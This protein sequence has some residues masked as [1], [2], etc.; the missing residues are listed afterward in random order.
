VYLIDLEQERHLDVMLAVGDTARV[1][2]VTP[3][4]AHFYADQP[5]SSTVVIG[6]LDHEVR[7]AV[8]NALAPH[9][10]NYHPGYRQYGSLYGL[11]RRDAPRGTSRGQCDP[12]RELSRVA[13]IL[14]LVRPHGMSLGDAARIIMQP[15]GRRQIS[16][17]R[18]EGPGSKAY[19]IEPHDRWIR[20]EDVGHTR[21]L[22]GALADR[23]LPKRVEWAMVAHELLHWQYHIE[24]RW[25][26]LC[27]ALEGMV[28]TDDRGLPSQMQ[29]REQFVVRLMKL[30]QFVPQLTW[31]E[32]EL[33]ATYDHRNETMHGSDV[34][35]LW[36]HEPFPPLYK[37]AEAGLRAIVREAIRRPEVADIF[38][39]D[40]S[41]RSSLGTMGRASRK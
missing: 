39:S 35:T 16:P 33:D 1:T 19:V 26:L 10:E 41:I 6:P 25:L 21:E 23:A 5:L 22:L 37:T 14:R 20:D 24:V 38:S 40:V 30:V 4:A 12:D 7:E 34:R 32:G 17:S 28:H 3:E 8:L 13:A 36:N 29:N 9:G 27:T 2:G 11:I 15:D 31:T 18:V